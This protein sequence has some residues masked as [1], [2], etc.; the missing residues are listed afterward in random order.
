MLGPTSVPLYLYLYDTSY[1]C[2]RYAIVSATHSHTNWGFYPQQ[3]ASLIE[4]WMQASASPSLS[5]QAH[6]HRCQARGHFVVVLV[7]VL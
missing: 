7:L 2:V 5:A 6:R 4:C 3:L 1:M